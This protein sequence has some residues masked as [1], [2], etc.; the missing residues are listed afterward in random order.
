MR[1]LGAGQFGTAALAPHSQ[2]VQAR[3]GRFVVARD[4][5]ISSRGSRE[6]RKFSE[7]TSSL[8]R[9]K[10]SLIGRINSLIRRTNS[11]FELPPK[12]T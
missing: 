2:S 12:R 4:R 5:K 9:T 11:L 7:G 6:E 10:N 8:Y 3:K 1:K